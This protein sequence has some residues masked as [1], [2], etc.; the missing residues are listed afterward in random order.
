[1]RPSEGDAGGELREL[2]DAEPVGELGERVPRRL[3]GEAGSLQGAA[4]RGVAPAVARVGGG[5][6]RGLDAGTAGEEDVHEVEVA[7]KGVAE[8]LPALL[9][10]VAQQQVGEDEATDGGGDREGDDEARGR[11][12]AHLAHPPAD[13]LP[14][15]PRFGH[16]RPIPDDDRADGAGQPFREA[17]GRRIGV[18]EERGS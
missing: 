2:V 12:D 11:E 6:Q 4:D 9:G 14:S 15:A 1:M 17:E 5:V 13:H 10:G 18:G 16:E 8:A 7:G 3:D